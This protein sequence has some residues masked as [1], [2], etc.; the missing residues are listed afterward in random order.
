MVDNLKGKS[1]KAI[2]ENM[3]EFECTDRIERNVL[4]VSA[5]GLDNTEIMSRMDSTMT[6]RKMLTS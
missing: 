4:I 6:D 3:N 5:M 2:G 1:N